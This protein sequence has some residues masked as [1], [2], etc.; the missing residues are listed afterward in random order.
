M[1]HRIRN[2]LAGFSHEGQGGS[3]VVSQL[4]IEPSILVSCC[5]FTSLA[6]E[7]STIILKGTRLITAL[8][9]VQGTTCRGREVT[10]APTSTGVLVEEVVGGVGAVGV[11][12]TTTNFCVTSIAGRSKL[13]ATSWGAISLS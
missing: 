3:L 11:V 9:E 6:L 10:L 8:R 7:E 4:R 5:R 13:A 2:A 1:L 12:C